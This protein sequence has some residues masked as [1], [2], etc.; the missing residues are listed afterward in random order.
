MQD[1]MSRQLSLNAANRG[2]MP[3]LNDAWADIRTQAAPHSAFPSTAWASE[4]RPA[5]FTP[6]PNI[7]QSVPQVNG[8]ST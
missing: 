1:L 6:G 2:A 3:S 7:Q 8:A 5:A 4:F